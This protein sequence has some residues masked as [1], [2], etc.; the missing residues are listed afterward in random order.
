MGPLAMGYRRQALFK[1]S[2]FDLLRSSTSRQQAYKDIFICA[3]EFSGDKRNM[4]SARHAVFRV[5]FHVTFHV[6]FHAVLIALQ[7]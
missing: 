5:A 6:A 3:F 1:K 7:R 4:V 2:S